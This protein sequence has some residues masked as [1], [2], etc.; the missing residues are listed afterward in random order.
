[1][2]FMM[3]LSGPF[4][5]MKNMFWPSKLHVLFF[6]MNSKSNLVIHQYGS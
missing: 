1:M 4:I 2:I 5:K 3:P 6:L